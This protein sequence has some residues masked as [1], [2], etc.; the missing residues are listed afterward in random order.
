MPEIK[1][2][3]INAHLKQNP[4]G[5]SDPVFLVYG[6]PFLVEKAASAVVKAILPDPGKKSVQ[7]GT[8]QVEMMDMAEGHSIYDIVEQINTLSFF[9]QMKIVRVKA[10]PLFASTFKAETHLEKIEAA[11]LSDDVNTAAR[12]LAVLMAKLQVQADDIALGD[13]AEA[14]KIDPRPHVDMAWLKK[15]AAYC[16]EKEILPADS[17]GT[18]GILKDAIARGFPKG[19]V[20]MLTAAS[21]DR[22]SALFKVISAD[23]TVVNCAVATGAR[24]ADVDQQKQVLKGLMAQMISEHDKTADADVFEHLFDLTGFEPGIFSA[25]MEKL[26]HYAGT[27]SRITRRHVDAVL[28]K[29]REDP[30]F[31][32]TGAI[33]ERN[34]EKA[35]YYLNSLFASGFH[36]MQLLN[37]IVNQARRLLMVKLF[38]VSPGGGVWADG[39]G[40]DRF[41]SAV[42]PVVIRYDQELNARGGG[43]SDPEEAG[44][45][46]NAAGTGAPVGPGKKKKTAPAGAKASS[47]LAIVKNPNSPYPVYQLFLQ[48]GRFSLD[49]L[50]ALMIRLHEADVRLKSSGHTPKAVLE[51]LILHI[52]ISNDRPE[53]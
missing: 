16:S 21:V 31:A 51:E 19:H 4:P 34:M 48:S 37:A 23:H 14:L 50:K 13:A 45:V 30:V 29:S 35:V 24:K 28:D 22:R 11:R 47:D 39:M 25:S 38:T 46:Q 5:H 12:L 53:T 18:A 33:F 6:E 3:Q 44:D 10:D 9:G 1:Y 49:G 2:N 27:A 20:L 8:P 32:F 36:Y 17:A 42:L 40:F 52:C 26:I 7:S 15:V 41:R 43:L